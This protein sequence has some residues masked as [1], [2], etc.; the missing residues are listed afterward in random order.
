MVSKRT[1][2]Q[3]WKA[4]DRGLW[5]YEFSRFRKASSGLAEPQNQGCR[6]IGWWNS[7]RRSFQEGAWHVP[8]DVFQGTRIQRIAQAFHFD[9]SILPS[10][11]PDARSRMRIWPITAHRMSVTVKDTGRRSLVSILASSSHWPRP[12]GKRNKDV[13]RGTAAMIVK[14]GSHEN[15]QRMLRVKFQ[16]PSSSHRST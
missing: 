10:R 5:K 7:Q 16:N 12:A 14:L 1:W 15:N 6:W 3:R 11:I 2:E 8:P 13:M 4:S 9:Q